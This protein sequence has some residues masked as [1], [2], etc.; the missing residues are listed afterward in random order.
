VP[1][2][3]RSGAPRRDDPTLMLGARR[4]ATINVAAMGN[5]GDDNESFGIVHRIDDA[6]IANADAEV[7]PTSKLY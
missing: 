7:I 1:G 3:N 5:P 2:C 6:V 4:S